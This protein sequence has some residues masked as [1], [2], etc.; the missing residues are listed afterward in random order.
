MAYEIPRNHN[1]DGY[2][3]ALAS[4]VYTFFDRKTGSGT[5]VNEELTI[6]NYKNQ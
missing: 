5:S 4:M 3:R 1:Y 6:K 2:K